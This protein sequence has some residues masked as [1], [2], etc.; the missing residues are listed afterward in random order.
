MKGKQLRAIRMKLGW[1]QMEMAKALKVAGNTVARWE[2]NER[3]ISP[4]MTKLVNIIF[5]N[6]SKRK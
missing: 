6:E 4:P 1:T 2:R 5:A 3:P